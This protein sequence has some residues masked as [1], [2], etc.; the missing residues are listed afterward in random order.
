V[1]RHQLALV[2]AWTWVARPTVRTLGGTLV[3]YAGTPLLLAVLAALALIG[4]RAA[5]ASRVQATATPLE[6]LMPW[7]ALPLLLP[8]V[9]SQVGPPVYIGKATIAASLAFTLLAA[10]G[11]VALPGRAARA[12][13]LV[14]F[15]AL[16]L[17]ALAT[18]FHGP[19]RERWREATAD[20]EAGARAGDLVVF[21]AGFCLPDVFAYY[22]RRTDLVERPF[23]ARAFRVDSSNVDELERLVD[24]RER[25][26]FVRSHDGDPLGLVPATLSRTHRLV[27]RRLYTSR[28]YELW[29]SRDYVGIEVDRFERVVPRP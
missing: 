28:T 12:V 9:V 1:L 6:V 11:L 5:R 20:L 23:P 13:A 24:G 7:L 3:E 19:H 25:V 2:D 16:S 26:W 27:A 17:P 29:R 22:A 10:R 15:V 8:F 4:V 14:A 18:Y 21:N